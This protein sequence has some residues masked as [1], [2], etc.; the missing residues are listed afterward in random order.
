MKKHF[1]NIYAL[2]ATLIK[3]KV[4]HFVVGMLGS[5]FVYGFTFNCVGPSVCK[6][7]IFDQFDSMAIVSVSGKLVYS[8]LLLLAHIS[9]ICIG[10]LCGNGFKGFSNKWFGLILLAFISTCLFYYCP[11]NF[12][13]IVITGW[14]CLYS[15]AFL[16]KPKN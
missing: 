4:L 12:E 3:S 7:S 8:F 13:Y 10:L 9:T 6:L 2:I 16:T 11:N 1:P 5:A 15:W 14:F